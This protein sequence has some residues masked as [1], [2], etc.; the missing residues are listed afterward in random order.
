[1]LEKI[2]PGIAVDLPDGNACSTRC[3][4][5]AGQSDCAAPLLTE[6]FLLADG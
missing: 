6:S 4:N 2:D 3:R 5:S 1:M